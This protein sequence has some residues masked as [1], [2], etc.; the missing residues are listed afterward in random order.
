VSWSSAQIQVVQAA[1]KGYYFEGNQVMPCPPGAFCPGRGKENEYLLCP[2]GSYSDQSRAERCKE[3]PIG[4][5]CP[6]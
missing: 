4:Y 1:P 6:F 3:C 2:V 5:V